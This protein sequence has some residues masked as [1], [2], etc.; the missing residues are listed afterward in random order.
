MTRAAGVALLLLAACAKQ[1]HA[2]VPTA[3][4]AVV[5]RDGGVADVALLGE[6]LVASGAW[7][8]QCVDWEPSKGEYP[9]GS[10]HARPCDARDFTLR[11]TCEGPCTVE[12]REVIPTAAG[13]ITVHVDLVRPDRTYRD[14]RRIEVRV[15]DGFWLTG[16]GNVAVRDGEPERRKPVR[17]DDV[18]C[19]V[20]REPIGLGVLAGDRAFDVAVEVAGG[21]AVRSLDRAALA[22][23]LGVPATAAGAYTVTLGHHGLGRR[24][25]LELR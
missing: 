3:H 7:A 25:V 22:A 19:V 1:V 4:L 16:C 12:G 9:D 10:G 20:G 5:G 18:R 13:E 15:A 2:P 24:V 8:G 23:R 17:V 14:D 11:V 21:P 6:R